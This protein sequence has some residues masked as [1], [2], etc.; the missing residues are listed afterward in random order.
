M[1][2]RTGSELTEQ[3][4]RDFLTT[5]GDRAKSQV[6]L[7]LLGGGGLS[8]LGNH[9][10]TLD[11]DY[12][13]EEISADEF[14]TLLEL[15]AAE[16]HIELEAVPLRRFIPLPPG[17]DGR[18]IPIGNFGNLQV[19]VFDQYSIALSKRDRGF[20][21]DIEDVVFLLR[22][23]FVEGDTLGAMITVAAE[24]AA[25]YDLNTRQM[26][27]HLGLAKAALTNH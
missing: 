2:S 21:S 10:L 17:A 3:R 11:I 24:S 19:F 1:G 12:D 13:G 23:G 8:L 5:V 18:H 16:M 15:V 4:L 14:R 9:R 27:A 6:V 26:R 25:E 7:V 22:E 20:D